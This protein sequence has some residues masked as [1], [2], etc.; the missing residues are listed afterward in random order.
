[1][2]RETLRQRADRAGEILRRLQKQYPDARCALS[3]ENAFQLLV[4]TI[5]SAQTTDK[6][7]NMV[8]PRLFNTYPDAA[9]LAAAPQQDVEKLIASTG[10]FRNKAKAIRGA[11]RQIVDR[12]GDV[13][14]TMEGLTALT[15]VGRKTANVVLGNAFGKNEG[16]VVDTH[17][18]RLSLRLGLTRRVDP[19]KAETDLTRLLPRD[20]WTCWSHLLIFHGRRICESRKPKCDECVLSNLCPYFQKMVRDG[21]RKNKTRNEN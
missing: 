13:P 11:A 16:I 8:T 21:D 14:D 18:G 3:H 19:V 9:A 10:F 17:V 15:G 6:R 12:G 4:A 1:M 5:L 2:P 20:A 7:V